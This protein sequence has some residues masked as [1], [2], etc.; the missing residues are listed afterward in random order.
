LRCLCEGA[1]IRKVNFA[2]VTFDAYLVSKKI[3]GLAFQ[4]GEPDLF[5]LWRQEFELMHP[6][7]FTAQKLYLLNPIRRR[8]QLKESAAP[9]SAE[10]PV[11]PKPVF[12]PKPKI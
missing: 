7:S 3:D 5:A 12:K 9:A 8:F 6:N 11:K 1:F 2:L 10:A 4:Q